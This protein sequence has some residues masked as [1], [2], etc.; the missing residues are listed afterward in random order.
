M[1][2]FYMFFSLISRNVRLLEFVEAAIRY[3]TGC[4][5]EDGSFDGCETGGEGEELWYGA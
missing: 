5:P 4:V 2:P 1:T 3:P